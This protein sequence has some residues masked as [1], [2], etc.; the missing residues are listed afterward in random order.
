MILIETEWIHNIIL[1]SGVQYSDSIFILPLKL[2]EIN[3]YISLSWKIY[4]CCC[5]SL[6]KDDLLWQV[7]SVKT[8]VMNYYIRVGSKDHAKL[9]IGRHSAFLPSSFTEGALAFSKAKS[10][11]FLSQTCIEPELLPGPRTQGNRRAGVR[12]W[13]SHLLQ[14]GLHWAK[15]HGQRQVLTMWHVHENK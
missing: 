9:Y 7:T 14:M 3:G 11:L 10:A 15:G 2:L 5:L 13:P 12:I 4:L 6:F 8:R 1:V